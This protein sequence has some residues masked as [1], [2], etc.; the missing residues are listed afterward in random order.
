MKRGILFSAVLLVATLCCAQTPTAPSDVVALGINFNQDAAQQISASALY[1]HY[2]PALKVYSFNLIDITS[3]QHVGKRFYAQTAVS[4]GIAQE[5]RTIGPA[6]I[7]ATGTFGMA[8]G[9]GATGVNVG[10]SWTAG[11]AAVIPV[12]K[13]GFAIVPNGRALKTSLAGYQTVIGLGFGW[14]K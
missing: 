7:F 4:T 14:G 1:A 3:V 13:R 2:I 11:L 8:V 9:D 12:G 6:R 5:V 10:N